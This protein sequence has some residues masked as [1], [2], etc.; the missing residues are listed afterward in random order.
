[1]QLPRSRAGPG[2]HVT[3]SCKRGSILE[4]QGKMYRRIINI[5]FRKIGEALG[6]DLREMAWPAELW[7]YDTQNLEGP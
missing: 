1:M 4:L 5:F 3:G 7:D 2:N 6:S